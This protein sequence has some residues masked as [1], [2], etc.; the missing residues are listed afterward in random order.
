MFGDGC[1]VQGEGRG[2]AAVCH[3]IMGIRPLF[4]EKCVPALIS[5]VQPEKKSVGPECNGAALR[6]FNL[7]LC[8]AEERERNRAIGVK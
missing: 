3:D 6:L 8:P 4:G 2:R 7:W 1:G 5:L